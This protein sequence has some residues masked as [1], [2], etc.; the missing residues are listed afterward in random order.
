[1]EPDRYLQFFPRESAWWVSPLLSQGTQNSGLIVHH[2]LFQEAEREMEWEEARRPQ[3]QT[4]CR[5]ALQTKV[6]AAGSWGEQ[7]KP[8]GE[9]GAGGGRGWSRGGSSRAKTKT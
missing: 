6:Q 5:K 2:F 3:T 8:H 9:A 7:R 4:A 1:M